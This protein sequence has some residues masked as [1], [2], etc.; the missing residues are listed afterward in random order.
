MSYPRLRDGVQLLVG[1][2]DLPLAYDGRTGRYHRLSRAAVATLRLLDG[3]R[4]AEEVTHA[5][6]AARRQE[7]GTARAELDLFLATLDRAGL[8]HGPAAPGTPPARRSLLLPR[9]VVT[10]ALPRALEPLADRLRTGRR[11]AV[12]MAVLAVAGVAGTALGIA[13]FLTA[14]RPPGWSWAF[15][16]AA[17]L[18]VLQVCVHE[19]AHALV[20]QVLRAP[21]RGAGFALLLWLLPVAFVDRTD[22]YRVRSRRGR[23]AL[24]LAGP[25]CDGVC[26][27]VTAALALTGH[28]TAVA[29]HL[30]VFQ[31]FALLLNVNP[32]L[33]SDGYVA[34]E[35]LFGLVDPR[36]RA[37]SLLAHTVRGR[38]LPP[39]LA[40]LPRRT[41]LVLVG[42]GVV[43]VA[44]LGLVAAT[45]VSGLLS[46]AARLLS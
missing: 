2:D 41:R 18:L 14:A 9:F 23:L 38:T 43:C 21:V 35:V 33:P 22:A 6:A 19:A 34:V 15:A 7:P 1:M 30:L 12:A 17:A 13:G 29:G 4:S 20:C 5:L 46:L 26:M 36:G 25:L 3:T 32:L 40:S 44:Y 27:G 8:L 39:H 37:L 24:T 28:G 10:R 42:Y 11:G 31:T 45:A 16:V